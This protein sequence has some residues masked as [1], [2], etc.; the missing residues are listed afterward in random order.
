MGVAGMWGLP[1]GYTLVCLTF[2]GFPKKVYSYR[3]THMVL[4]E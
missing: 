4:I 3:C 2:R 1:D